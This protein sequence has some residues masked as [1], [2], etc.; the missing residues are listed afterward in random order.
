MEKEEG[1]KVKHS[2]LRMSRVYFHWHV[3]SP[4]NSRII[5]ESR[6]FFRDPRT[7]IRKHR[8]I[9]CLNWSQPMLLLFSIIKS[10]IYTKTVKNVKKN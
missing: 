2:I 4:F 10:S 5:S 9:W 1:L 6:N 8:L 3:E 7:F